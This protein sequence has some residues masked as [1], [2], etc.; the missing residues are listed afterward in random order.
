MDDQY[1]IDRHKRLLEEKTKLVKRTVFASVLFGL[2]ILVNVLRPYSQGLKEKKKIEVEIQEYED[3]IKEVEASNLTLEKLNIVLD[4]IQKLVKERP[5]NSETRKLI[6]KYREMNR[7]GSVSR[8]QY[9][10]KADSTIIAISTLVSE[11]VTKPIQDFVTDSF[12][13]NKFLSDKLHREL[14]TLPSVVNTW[15]TENIGKYWYG[16]IHSKEAHVETLSQ[17]LGDKLNNISSIIDEDK[18]ILESKQKELVRRLEEITSKADY[19]ELKQSLEDLRAKMDEIL[20]QWFKG[21]ISVEQMVYLYPFI[22]ILLASY[23]LYTAIGLSSHFNILAKELNFYKN[24]TKD[25]SYTSLWTL[26]YRGKLSTLMTVCVYLLFLLV[27]WYFFESGIVILFK[28]I[29]IEENSLINAETIK[30]LSLISRALLLCFILYCLVK[31]YKK[32]KN[33]N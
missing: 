31:P 6:L 23:V 10:D 25:P 18:P 33:P 27:S 7:I 4:N 9:Q 2:F 29:S 20:P 14:E 11:T 30:V 15:K 12:V 24:S 1:R 22:I 26:T 16:T 28:F 3:Q 17:T 13:G 32:R 5:W 21:M 8:S 19:S